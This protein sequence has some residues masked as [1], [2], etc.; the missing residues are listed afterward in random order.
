MRPM[1]IAWI[2]LLLV[3]SIA[4]TLEAQGTF[5]ARVG[6]SVATLDTDAESI[7]DEDNRSGPVFGV[8]YNRD[9]GVLGYQLEV[10]YTKR[11]TDLTGGGSLD[12]AY[13]QIPALLKAG[14]PVGMLR[15]GIFGGIALALKV[16]CEV[17]DGGSS[18]CDDIS[19]F[20]LND[21]DWNAVFGVDLRLPLTA[22]SLWADGRY[23]MGLSDVGEFDDVVD[24][25]KNRS[26]EL[27]AGVGIG[28]P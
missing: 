23:Y 15:P 25:V 8:F 12:L 26:W 28:L 6:T 20:E 7:L 3:C 21:V 10:L 11:G 13:V 2:A 19:G 1:R 5:G 16:D 27:T 18:G 14:V 24:D 4:P 17:V 22:I 9:L